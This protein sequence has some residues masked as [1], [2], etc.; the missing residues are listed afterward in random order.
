MNLII[1]VLKKDDLYNIKEM[2]GKL[3]EKKF[4]ENDNILFAL[5]L[6]VE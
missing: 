5:P 2:N 4:Y 3:L 6:Y 1:S